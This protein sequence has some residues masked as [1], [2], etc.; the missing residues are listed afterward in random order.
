MHVIHTAA[1]MVGLLII[2][3]LAPYFALSIL[4]L[5]G[6]FA[7][8]IT[9]FVRRHKQRQAIAMLNFLLG[10]TVLGWAGAMI[11]SLTISERD[12]QVATS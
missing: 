2:G 6:Y 10:W 3:I 12:H 4:A 9:A 8:M 7:P 1:L 5:V 11:W